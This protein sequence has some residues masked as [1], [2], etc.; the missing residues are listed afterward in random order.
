MPSISKIKCPFCSMV[1]DSSLNFCPYCNSKLT[2]GYK[3]SKYV[4]SISGQI[5]GPSSSTTSVSPFFHELVDI[6]LKDN[7][8]EY[9]KKTKIEL[10]TDTDYLNEG[11]LSCLSEW[12]YISEDD[13]GYYRL[14]DL[15]RKSYRDNKKFREKIKK[16]TPGN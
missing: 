13:D 4:T 9:S 14:T 11:S 1:I 6:L 8:K 16:R 15:G 2:I 12:G 7:K 10:T 3:S 5:Y